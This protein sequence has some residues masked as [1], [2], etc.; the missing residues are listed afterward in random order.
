VPVL[1]AEPS[2]GRQAAKASAR[3]PDSAGLNGKK[4]EEGAAQAWPSREKAL[5]A[6]DYS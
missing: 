3:P 2:T 5:E 6:A 1:M 4:R